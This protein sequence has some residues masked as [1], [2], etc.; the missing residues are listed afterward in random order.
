MKCATA[1]GVSPLGSTLTASTRTCVRDAGER[2]R[3]VWFSC[4]AMTGQTF[5]QWT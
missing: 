4:P 1:V 2:S 5:V 3:S